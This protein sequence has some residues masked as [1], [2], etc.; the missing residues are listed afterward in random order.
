GLENFLGHRKPETLAAGARGHGPGAAEGIIERAGPLLGAHSHAGVLY[1]GEGVR[2]RGT[3]S[4]ADFTAVGSVFDRI[5]ED[6][7]ERALERDRIRRGRKLRPL[8]DELD[9]DAAAVGQ[10]V[11]GRERSEDLD[12]VR[13]LRRLEM[14]A[15][16][17]R[18]RRGSPDE[19]L[20]QLDLAREVGEVVRVRKLA[21]PSGLLDQVRV[22]A[23][24]R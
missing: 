16:I 24:Y 19:T 3:R 9:A 14:L 7:A 1:D 23:E 2:P 10:T 6:V 21:A 5:V 4:D 8:G 12:E 11:R 17:R 15:G 18:G 13:V 20:G 22:D